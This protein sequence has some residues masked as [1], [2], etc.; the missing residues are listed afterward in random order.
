[1]S[2]LT[3]LNVN[4]TKMLLF[5][6]EFLK[7][8]E[9]TRPDKLGQI[10][11]PGFPDKP[12]PSNTFIQWQLRADPNHVI[13]L[14]FDTMNLEENCK[15]DFVKIYDSLVAIESRVME[16]WVCTWPPLNAASSR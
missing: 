8:S 12:Y 9:H 13:K 15:N 6:S 1:M 10:Q 5:V 16:E 11:S 14:K 3:K 2:I 4:I 7:Y